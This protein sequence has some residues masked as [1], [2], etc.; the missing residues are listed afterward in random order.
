MKNIYIKTAVFTLTTVA[1][2]SASSCKK[3][4]EVSNPSIIEQ[5]VAFSNTSYTNLALVGVYNQLPGDNGYGNRLSALFPQTAD[6]FKTSGSY[7]ALDRRGISMYAASPDNTDL[8]N[9]FSQLYVGIER[10]N[11]CIKGIQQSAL[12]TSGAATDQKLMKQYLG[13]AYALR[14]QFYHEL[15]RNW[16]DVVAPFEPSAD[17]PSLDVPATKATVIYDRLLDDLAKAEEMVPWRSESGYES[18]RWTKGAIKGLRA[19]IALTRGGY[20]LNTTT[21]AFERSADYQKYYQIALQECK[22]VMDR[23]DQH[24]LNPV[25]EN[26]FKTLHTSTRTD[27]EH[28]LMFEVG[29][30]GGNATTDTKL[31]YYNGLRI[32]A[33]ARFGQGGGGMNAIPTYFYEFD[34]SGDVRRDVTIGS[35]EIDVNGQ[36]VLNALNNMTDGKFRRSWTNI[37]GTAQTLGIN[38]P[39]LRFADILLMY[40]EAENEINGPTALAQAALLEVRRRA[41]AGNE[42]RIPAAP[43][44][45]GEFFDAIV[46][47]RLLEFGGEGVRKYDLIRWKLIASKFA[48]TRTKL[49]QLMNGEGAYASLPLYV[50]AKPAT[51]SLTNSSAEFNTLD[52]SGGA[53]SAPPNTVLFQPGSGSATA[54]SGYTVKQWRKVLTEDNI[55]GTSSGFATF[56]EPNKKEVFPFP[57]AALLR[58]TQLKQNFGY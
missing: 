33:A 54:P 52:V 35:Y 42:G 6:D 27:S 47:E 55:A 2:L 53:G 19:R 43:G 20:L 46:K 40:A 45:K 22:D 25:Y 12:Y 8:I 24:T 23:R 38:W 57:A 37:V 30:F 31:G 16:G 14:A 10:A 44:G 36:K 5:E 56:F 15:I 7:S 58:N 48:E 18:T 29:A 41:F 17:Q 13:E 3:Y 1:L 28:E 11:I 32:N 26:I 39:I 51:Y 34:E 50:Y 21:H 4:L 49:R 9:P